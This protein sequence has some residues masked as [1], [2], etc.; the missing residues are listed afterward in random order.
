MMPGVLELQLGASALRPV[1]SAAQGG[2]VPNVPK[3]GKAHAGVLSLEQLLAATATLK[4]TRRGARPHS[5]AEPLASP[6][7]AARVEVAKARGRLRKAP[8]DAVAAKAPAPAPT[9]DKENR[10]PRL[11]HCWAVTLCLRGCNPVQSL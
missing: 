6:S 9:I 8:T 7:Y 10:S 2:G 5:D 1:D 3:G 11:A 4:P